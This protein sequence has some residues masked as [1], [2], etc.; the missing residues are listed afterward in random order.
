MSPRAR[1]RRGGPPFSTFLIGVF[2]T[3]GVPR[4]RNVAPGC[5]KDDAQHQQHL[6]DSDAPATIKTRPEEVAFWSI[7]TISWTFLACFSTFFGLLSTF[8]TSRLA[9]TRHNQRHP[10]WTTSRGRLRGIWAVIQCGRRFDVFGFQPGGLAC[11]SGDRF[12][13]EPH[14]LCA[15]FLRAYATIG[16][17]CVA[18]R[19][20]Y[21]MRR[22]KRSRIWRRA[23]AGRAEETRVEDAL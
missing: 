10:G 20:R 1:I 13:A 11:T 18:R 17:R 2:S 16:G 21:R 3:F 8:S 9:R 5:R 19:R 22:T 6:K 12:G 14:A 23:R 7:S 15:D 4:A